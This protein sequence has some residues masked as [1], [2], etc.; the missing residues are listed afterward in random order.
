MS[1]KITKVEFIDQSAD[2][3]KKKINNFVSEKIWSNNHEDSIIQLMSGVE[4]NLLSKWQLTDKN[5]KNIL[6]N[7]LKDNVVVDNELHDFLYEK[8]KHY[9]SSKPLYISQHEYINHEIGTMQVKRI[10]AGKK[11]LKEEE[12]ESYK[13]D[14]LKKYIVFKNQIDNRYREWTTHSKWLLWNDNDIK[15]FAKQCVDRQLNFDIKT[16]QEYIHEL[17]EEKNAITETIWWRQWKNL[18]DKTILE[19][20]ISKI[21]IT[22]ELETK[23]LEEL[24]YKYSSKETLH[25]EY[26]DFTENIIE[27]LK[28]YLF[29]SYD[30]S[31][32]NLTKKYIEL[33]ILPKLEGKIWFSV[34]KEYD[35]SFWDS[36]LS[37]IK[38]NEQELQDVL[39]KYKDE[40]IYTQWKIDFWG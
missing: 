4:I 9:I 21:D 39:K 12:L 13:K 3:I 35:L 10:S 2:L 24:R 11:Y 19:G 5:K 28:K 16:T 15:S 22:L 17:T 40:E 8:I 29:S 20:E 30:H 18:K 14:I 1:D 36:V 31:D 32:K 37:L 34:W 23:F 27:I 33:F 7:L 38:K 6:I 26:Q 25:K